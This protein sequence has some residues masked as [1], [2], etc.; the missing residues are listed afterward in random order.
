LGGGGR[1]QEERKKNEAVFPS[2]DLAGKKKKTRKETKVP[3]KKK[4]GIVP[5]LPW[6]ERKEM[7]PAEGEVRQK[8]K[9]KT[10]EGRRKGKS[11]CESAGDA[12]EKKKNKKGSR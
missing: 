11:D 8:E 10:K 6:K 5:C 3:G 12:K 4:K 7:T 9:E 2:R 1:K